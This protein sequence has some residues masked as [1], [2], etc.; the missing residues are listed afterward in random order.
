MGKF[1]AHSSG[2]RCGSRETYLK[3]KMQPYDK[4]TSWVKSPWNYV[5]FLLDSPLNSL[6]FHLG[7]II[8]PFNSFLAK[9]RES[10]GTRVPKSQGESGNFAKKTGW[11][12]DEVSHNFAEFAVVKARFL[13][14]NWQI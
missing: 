1:K 3:G 11:K 13:R 4:Y 14:V 8:E 7:K 10:Q 6:D 2:I 9:A 5:N 12:P